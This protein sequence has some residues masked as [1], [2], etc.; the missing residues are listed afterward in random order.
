MN[1]SSKAWKILGGIGFLAAVV[2]LAIWLGS[3]G[4][5]P[6]DNQP[7]TAPVEQAANSV[8]EEPKHDPF[9]TTEARPSPREIAAN[10]NPTPAPAPVPDPNVLTNWEDRIDQILTSDGEDP[11][12]AKQMLEM[13]PRLPEDGQV[14]VA[15]HLSNLT[16]DQDYTQLSKLLTNDALPESVLD[17]LLADTLNR[18]NSLKLP[19][20]L[21]VARDPQN[22][23]AGEAKDL[24]QLFLDQDYGTDWDAWQ[25]QMQTWLKDNP[26]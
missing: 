8:P 23:K 11:A 13:F 25:S 1:E 3:K 16:P 20:L 15:Q 17:V 24:L 9:F 10:P 21:E 5:A 7:S 2:V 14:E 26:D 19:S 22:P 6:V 4:S 12:K 18:P